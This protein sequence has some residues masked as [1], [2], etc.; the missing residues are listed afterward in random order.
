MQMEQAAKADVTIL[1]E[2]TAV[3]ILL[4]IDKRGEARAFDLRQIAGG[5]DRM[6]NLTKR[7][8]SIGLLKIR[9]EE[10]PRLTYLYSLTPKG[11]K[12]A[13]KLMEIDE[14]IRSP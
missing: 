7:M 2:P 4:L 3:S 8:E 6:K 14:I 1:D 10:K 11:K 12:V 9:I 5:Y 13:A